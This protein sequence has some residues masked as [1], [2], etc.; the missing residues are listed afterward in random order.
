MAGQ[1]IRASEI[2]SRWATRYVKGEDFKST[3]WD[4]LTE[5]EKK[6]LHYFR[7]ADG[8]PIKEKALMEMQLDELAEFECLRTINAQVSDGK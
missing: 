8:D 6:R 2:K 5:T 1:E 3:T 4:R 7:L